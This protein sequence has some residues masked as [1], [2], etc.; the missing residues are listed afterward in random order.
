MFDV[1]V[2]ADQKVF[3]YAIDKSQGK[4]ICSIHAICSNIVQ[5]SIKR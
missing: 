5:I 2:K 1:M 3:E 4:E